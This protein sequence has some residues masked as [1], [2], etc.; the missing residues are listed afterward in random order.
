MWALHFPTSVFLLE[1]VLKRFQSIVNFLSA[2]YTHL[3]LEDN[4]VVGDRL[5]IEL[6]HT[7]VGI[8][9]LS[10]MNEYVGK[11]LSLSKPQLYH[12]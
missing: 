10:C 6:R 4:I 11:I 1:L 12:L 9:A 8:V 5:G 3:R 7:P 2:F